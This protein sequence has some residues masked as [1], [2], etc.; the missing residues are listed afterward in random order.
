MLEYLDDLK[1]A[2]HVLKSVRNNEVDIKF[3]NNYSH[4]IIAEILYMIKI[5]V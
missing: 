4:F 1:K 3:L 5:V 2:F